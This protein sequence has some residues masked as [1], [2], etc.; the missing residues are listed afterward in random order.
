MPTD[1]DPQDSVQASGVPDS[2]TE[3]VEQEQGN[4]ENLGPGPA[5]PKD[6]PSS[7]SVTHAKGNGETEHEEEPG[8]GPNHAEA[9]HEEKPGPSPDQP[10]DSPSSSGNEETVITSTK[11]ISL[12]SCNGR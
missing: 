9:E 1:S 3:G 11:L 8:L 12:H 5:Q 4:K 10:E 6:L 2:N 7:G